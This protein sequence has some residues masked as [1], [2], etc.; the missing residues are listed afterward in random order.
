MDKD[1]LSTELKN[2]K[3]I[4]L[5]ASE[6]KKSEGSVRYWMKKYE[7]KANL[8]PNRTWTEEEMTSSIRSSLTISDV[9][10][11]LGL[12]VR[13]GNYRTVNKFI[14][15][16]DIDVSHM[17]GCGHGRGGGVSRKKL[18]EVLVKNSKYSR[19]SLKKRLLEE[20]LLSNKCSE[21]ELEDVWRNQSIRMVLDHINGV[22]NDNR[23]ENL[24]MLC[25][26]C[27]SQQSTFC[28]GQGKFLAQVCKDE[29]EKHQ[30]SKINRC[31][32]GKE[33]F[34]TSTLC[35]KCRGIGIRKVENRPAKEEL[36]RLLID[37]TWVAIGREYGV[38]DNAIRRWAKNYGLI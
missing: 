7:L 34:R 16:N 35:N 32:C 10:K 18:E 6:N 3:T 31:T 22:N 37:N 2:G 33:I 17:V 12:S 28:S 38:S 24:R 1:Y 23:L 4:K 25:P 19:Q 14:R 15:E 26:N 21:C 8:H 9:L 30:E 11:N 13:P 20:G 36:K 29:Y 27:N 5:I